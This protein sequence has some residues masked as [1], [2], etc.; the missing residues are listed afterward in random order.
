M[1]VHAWATVPSLPLL[2]L[3]RTQTSQT[4]KHTTTHFTAPTHSPRTRIPPSIMRIPT[5][6]P[7]R[8]HINPS[9]VPSSSRVWTHGFVFLF[10]ICGALCKITAHHNKF[11]RLQWR[12]V[13]D[14]KWKAVPLL[15]VP[16]LM[17]VASSGYFPA[18]FLM[19]L[20]PQLRRDN[21]KWSTMKSE[22]KWGFMWEQK[23]RQR[24]NMCTNEG[25][26]RRL[27]WRGDTN[28]RQINR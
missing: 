14:D 10:H 22:M 16:L 15:I 9:V 17:A 4:C 19:G 21:E 23:Y 24:E 25:Q 1:Y 18:Q 3:L 20:V 2:Y 28:K 5:L 6:P 13:T 11:V 8:S 7:P 27:S 26:I 12:S